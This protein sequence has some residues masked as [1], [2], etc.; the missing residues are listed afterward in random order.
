M[1]KI[2][3]FGLSCKHCIWKNQVLLINWLIPSYNDIQWCWD[4]AMWVL[5]RAGTG[6]LVK[7]EGKTNATKQ[8]EVFDVNCSR[9][10]TISDRCEDFLQNSVKSNQTVSL[11]P[12]LASILQIINYPFYHFMHL[13]TSTTTVFFF[14][15]YYFILLVLCSLISLFFFT[16][17]MCYMNFTY[18]NTQ[19]ENLIHEYLQY[20]CVAAWYYPDMTI[21]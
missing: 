10:H 5:L 8:R 21:F 2:E 9:V 13:C 12:R 16:A 7:I 17:T 18:Y 3:L 20:I 1:I 4:F 6:R 11:P 14:F 19:L 15:N